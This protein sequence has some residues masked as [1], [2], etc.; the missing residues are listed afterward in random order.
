MMH[1]LCCLDKDMSSL[2]RAISNAQKSFAR[3]PSDYL[4][5]NYTPV[6]SDP[7]YVTRRASTLTYPKIY[8]F[9]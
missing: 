2:C 5:E 3:T 4:F 7:Y 1:I 8:P 9:F 6:D